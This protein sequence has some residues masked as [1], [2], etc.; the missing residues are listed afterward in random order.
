MSSVVECLFALKDNV[1]TGSRQNNSNNFKT[2]IYYDV[3][4]IS[5]GGKIGTSTV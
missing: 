3:R 4:E 1:V 2:I 5:E